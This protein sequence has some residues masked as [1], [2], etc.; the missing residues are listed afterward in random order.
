MGGGSDGSG[1]VLAEGCFMKLS[2]SGRLKR[3]DENEFEETR[4]KRL[5]KIIK[6]HLSTLVQVT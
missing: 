4:L 1:Y 3:V 5:V 6:Q 2:A